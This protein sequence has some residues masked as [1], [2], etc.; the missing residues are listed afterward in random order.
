MR[1]LPIVSLWV[2]VLIFAGPARAHHG[3]AAL[4]VAGPEGPGAGLE[5]TSPLPLSVDGVYVFAKS[6]Y[7]PFERY[8]FAAPEN[9]VASAYNLLGFGYGLAPW[10]SVWAIQP[11]SVKEADGI[12]TSSGLGDTQLLLAAA[13][14]WDEGFRLVPERESLDELYDWHFSLW[15]ASTLPVGPT[16]ERGRGRV[17]FAPDMQTGFGQPSPSAGVAAAKQVGEDFTWLADAS[18]QHFFAHEYSYAPYRF[19]GETRLNTALAWRAVAADLFRLDVVGEL[20]GLHLQRDREESEDGA[21]KSLT[22]SGGAILYAGG[23]VRLTY[24]S[25]VAA[26]GLRRA[27]F[28][29][30]NEADEQQGS[31]GKETLRASLSLGYSGLW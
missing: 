23:G 3:T 25:F 13:F 30:L 20:N 19:G 8:S 21:M 14:K 17:F 12:G 29:R 18:Y 15:L 24:G 11:Y 16:E 22:A 6:E 31:E 10:L 4:G 28:T 2:A 5:T 26:L 1:L 27:A 9:K 7:V